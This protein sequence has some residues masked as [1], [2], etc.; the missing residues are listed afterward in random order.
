MSLTIND[1]RMNKKTWVEENYVDVL[2]VLVKGLQKLNNKVILIDEVIDDEVEKLEGMIQSKQVLINEQNDK[3]QTLVTK[4]NDCNSKIDKIEDEWME[5]LASVSKDLDNMIND[6]IKSIEKEI[7][8]KELLE[9]G[10]R[11]D[12]RDTKTVRQIECEVGFLERTHG[13]ALFTRGEGLTHL[14]LDLLIF[15]P[16]PLAL[17]RLRRPD[18][19]DHSRKLSNQL[20]VDSSDRNVGG[21]RRIQLEPLRNRHLHRMTEANLQN[22]LLALDLRVVADSDDLELASDPLGN[23]LNHIRQKR[24]RRPMI[25]TGKSFII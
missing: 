2:I 25:G 18:S 16:D 12:G 21:R 1:P 9:T 4:I 11:I 24:P 10:N 7:V 23:A 6:I 20:F 19:P 17:I 13:S 15:I 22:E 3:I 14:E 5:E 8:R